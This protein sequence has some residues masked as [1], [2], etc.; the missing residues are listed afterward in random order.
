MIEEVKCPICSNK[1]FA[2]KNFDYHKVK[3]EFC[4]FFV[5][6]GYRM[7]NFDFKTYNRLTQLI[8]A[9][10][11]LS[12]E[13][14]YLEF[15]SIEQLDEIVT[16]VNFPETIEQK[17][18]ILLKYILEN[19]EDLNSGC[20]VRIDQYMNFALNNKMDLTGLIDFAIDKKL[21]TTIKEMSTCDGGL[22][23]KL[24]PQGRD[25]LQEMDR[26]LKRDKNKIVEIKR[27]SYFSETMLKALE[28]A[29]NEISQGNPE[30]AHDRM[31]TFLHDF[32]I[33]L[34]AKLS[35]EPKSKE[36]NIMELFSLIKHYLNMN[37][38]NKIIVKILRS[39]SSALHD[40]NI[41]RND[42]SLSHPNK[43]LEKPEAM[44]VINTIKT[45]Y[46]YLEEKLN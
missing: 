37:N 34:C 31:H 35:L 18:D 24:K 20:F 5:L 10:R 43:V 27:N 29:E 17:T 23:C 12:S 1:A 26:I 36:P 3:C 7:M 16:R 8:Y 32:L 13:D 41:I 22:H 46:V 15:E 4:G 33:Q 44:F 2:I 38:P 6:I 19:E 25:R 40:I 42:E 30:H 39:F 14:N 21:I 9:I 28:A 45:I 11:I